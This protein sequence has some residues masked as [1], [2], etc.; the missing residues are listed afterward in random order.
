[1]IRFYAPG[2]KDTLEL[3]EAE[4]AHCVRVLR[5][6]EGDIINVV[7]GAGFSYEC[8]ITSAHARHTSVRILNTIKEHNHWSPRITLAVAPT[9]NMDRVEWVVEKAV[10]IGVDRIVFLNCEHNVRRVVKTERIEKIMVSAMKQSL[11][12][13]LPELVEIMDINRFLSEDDSARKFIAYCDSKMKRH[14]FAQTYDGLSDI[15]I[16]IGP[17]GDFTPQEVEVALRH[18]FEAVT[19]G[20]TRLRTETAAIYAL[21]ATHTIISQQQTV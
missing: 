4:S 5:M 14:E 21:C 16:L 19:F 10:E 11:K 13:K 20:N 7:D 12:S 2:I 9:K 1:M 18:G 15:C 3:P 17:E 6:Q 8:E